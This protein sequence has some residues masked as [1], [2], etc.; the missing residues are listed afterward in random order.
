MSHI[1]A[2]VERGYSLN[3]TGIIESTTTNPH[4]EGYSIGA[5]DLEATT[6]HQNYCL[7][8]NSE[9]NLSEENLMECGIPAFVIRKKLLV[10]IHVHQI[11][12]TANSAVTFTSSNNSSPCFS[13]LAARRAQETSGRSRDIVF[14]FFFFYYLVLHAS[15][16]AL[17]RTRKTQFFFLFSTS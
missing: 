15:L 9:V 16:S 4:L 14:L 17:E 2:K 8:R 11:H 10:V 5:C 3:N 6:L 7:K 1:I 12:A 13:D